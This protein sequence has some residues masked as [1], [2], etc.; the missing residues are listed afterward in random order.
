MRRIEDNN[1]FASFAAIGEG[2]TYSGFVSVVAYFKWLLS[3]SSR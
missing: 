3:L 2:G 1:L